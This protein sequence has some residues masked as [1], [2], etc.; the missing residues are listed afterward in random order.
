FVGGGIGGGRAK[1]HSG[2]SFGE[3][4]SDAGEQTLSSWIG[5][6]QAF[7]GVEVDLAYGFHLTPAVRL[8]YFTTRPILPHDFAMVNLEMGLGYRF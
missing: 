6:V 7:G 1:L 8:L 3:F 2:Y 5:G 4:F